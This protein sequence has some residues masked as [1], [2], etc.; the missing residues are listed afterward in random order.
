MAKSSGNGETKTSKSAVKRKSA[1]RKKKAVKKLSRA[2]KPAEMSLEQWQTELRR[3]FGVDQEF[4]WKNVGDHPFFS[5]YEVHN[6]ASGKTYPVRVRG[7]E[8][9]DNFCGCADFATNTLGTCKHL[10]FV[11]ARLR[12]KRGAKKAFQAGFQQPYSEIHLHYGAQRAVRFRPGSECPRKVARL[13]A[14]YF[15]SQGELTP[16]G[17]ASFEVLLSEAAKT[18]HETRCYEDVLMFV[19]ENRDAKQRAERLKKA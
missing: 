19:A 11:L 13:T 3:Q 1:S 9:G 14:K 12:R 17:F 15:D 16:E 5:E 18:G 10:E 8:S 6:P 7:T 4:D 2:K